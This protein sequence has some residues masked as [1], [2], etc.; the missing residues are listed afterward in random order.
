MTQSLG[1]TL[2]DVHEAAV[3]IAPYVNHTPVMSAASI[4]ELAGA[5]LLFKCENFQR[6]GAFKARGATNAVFALEA[7]AA[8]RGVA[9]HSSGNHGA[10]L[11]RAAALRGIP[12]HVVVPKGANPVKRAAIARYGAR[13]I[14]C[15]PSMAGREAALAAV[16]KNTGAN[17]V[18]PYANAHVMAGQ[19]TLA[20][21]LFADVAPL[22]VLLVP[23][24]GGGLV[25]G[26]ATVARAVSPHTR[27]IGVEPE[28]AADALA[29]FRAGSVRAVAEPDTIADGLR[30]TVGE[31]NLAIIRETVDDIVTV[32]D[33]QIIAAMRLAW[34]RLKIVI[35][36][37]AA[38]GLA[39]ALA[40]SGVSGARTGIV[41]T[42]G[43]ADLDNI[44]WLLPGT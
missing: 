40:Y 38:V 27:V 29:S 4:D 25:S 11:A 21:E 16:V 2:A 23:I 19:G 7:S 10:A 13:I 42:G 36:P 35:E 17:V 9:T 3:R 15:E 28:G 24:G 37:S 30:A 5:E 14:D 32:T 8:Q 20:L 12:C 26:C 1:L 43:N 6:V 41:L 34:E 31:P 18:H 22:D 44:P 33:A 39:A